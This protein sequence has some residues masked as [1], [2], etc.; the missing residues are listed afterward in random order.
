MMHCNKLTCGIDPFTLDMHVG[1]VDIDYSS[2]SRNY[3]VVSYISMYPKAATEVE[4]IYDK[5][6]HSNII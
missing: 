6:N 1:G 4:V 2:R 5:I 3:K